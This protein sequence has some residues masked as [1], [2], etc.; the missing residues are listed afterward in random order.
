MIYQDADGNLKE[1]IV[2][3]WS[4][5]ERQNQGQPIYQLPREG[6]NIVSIL[7]I[8]DTFLIGLKE[9]ELEVYRNDLSTLSKHLYR[10]QKLSGMY[11]TFRHHLASTLN[12]EREEFRIQSLEAW[13]RANPVKVQ[14]D[15]IGRIT[16]L[17]GPLC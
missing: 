15:E 3:F 14:I 7:Q 6:R 1:E 11:Y 8:N 4:V 10:V 13:K 2:S 17:N 9:E 16:F 12:N 5:I